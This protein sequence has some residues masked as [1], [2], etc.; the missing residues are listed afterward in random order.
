MFHLSSSADGR[1]GD[2]IPVDQIIAAID[3][4]GIKEFFEHCPDGPVIPFIHGEAE[5][6]PIAGTPKPFELLDDARFAFFF[7]FPHMG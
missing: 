2:G 1:L 4:A 3:Q 6:R 5:A 7:P